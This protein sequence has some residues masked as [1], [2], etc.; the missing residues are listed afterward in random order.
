M[1]IS[2]PGITKL[3]LT[4][5]LTTALIFGVVAG[6]FAVVIWFSGASGASA[7]WLWIGFSL[8]ML[9]IQWYFGPGIIIWASKAKEV[10]ANEEPKLHAIV[11]ELARLAGIPKP[12]VFIVPNNSPNAFAFGRT[13]ASAGV[14]VHTGLM[15]IL[16]EDEVRAVLAHEIG[17]IKHRDVTVMT[18]ASVLPI[19]L[20]YAVLIFGSGD[21]RNRGLGSFIMVFLG[22]I[23]AQI[24]GRLVVMWL[25]RQREYYADAFSAY[26]TKRPSSLM[27]ALAKITYNAAPAKKQNSMLRAFYI[28][29]PSAG[30]RKAMAEVIE[31][32]GMGDA[33]IEMAIEKEK[34]VGV[35]EWLSTH[36]ATWKRLS[37]LLKLKKQ[38]ALAG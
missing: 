28:A 3:N 37:S 35:K 1:A 31:V 14:A 13:Q 24:L 12:K 15:R 2:V 18:V 11:S 23:L 29:E 22:A 10:D 34:K 26:A 32:L 6:I 4:I 21:S 16:D 19:M 17:H 7:I 9:G 38:M 33:A 30:E 20:Y 36:P 25:S 27:R 8:L 5:L